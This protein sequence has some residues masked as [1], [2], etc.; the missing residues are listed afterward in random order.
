[1]AE[2][3]SD[4]TYSE[5]MERVMLNNGHFAP[6]KLVYREIWNYKDRA[7]VKGL[8][9]EQTI[10]ERAQRD[11][12]FTRIGLGVYAL[13]E[14]LPLLKSE[15]EH[16][17]LLD[18]ESR[19]H[20]DIQGMLLEIGNHRKKSEVADT[21]TGDK[22]WRFQD[23]P[24]HLL[25]TLSKVPPFTYDRIIRDSVRYADVIWFNERGFPA[26][27]FEVEHSTDFR[28]A[29]IKFCELQDFNT[30]FYCV[31][32]EDREEKFEREITKAAF[33]SIRER[34]KFQS[35]EAVE[36][37]YQRSLQKSPF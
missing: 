22:N 3:K 15:A 27:V 36:E 28:S 11:K 4:L 1:M 17:P 10:Q 25:S 26:K 31:S 9:P 12:R 37:T 18:A 19:T 20:A 7:K 8:T 6:L 35:Y 34:C 32:K 24:L 30:L 21:Y 16:Q 23:K 29:L 14:H 5:A 13:T 2:K 33:D